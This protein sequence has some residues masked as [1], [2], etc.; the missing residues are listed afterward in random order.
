MALIVVGSANVDLVVRA[1]RLPKTGETLLG[2]SFATFPGGKGAN[3]AVAAARLGGDVRFFGCV[4]D[5]P[6]AGQLRASLL[7]AG[8][9]IDGLATDPAVPTGIA[10]ITVD[11]AGQNTIVVAPGANSRVDPQPA[12]DASQP[13]DVLLAQ[14]EI[15]VDAVERLFAETSAAVK[16]LNP[17]PACDLPP[18]LYPLI[19][20]ITPNEAEAEVLTGIRPT[21]EA[22]CEAAASELLRR[23]V[24]QVLITLGAQGC[25]YAAGSIRK[26]YPAWPV[27][28]IDTVAAGDAFSGALGHFLAIGKS[29]DT[30]IRLATVAAA[31]STTKAGAQPSLPTLADL[32]SA[33]PKSAEIEI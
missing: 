10:V 20:L 22:S 33:L 12:I 15:P 16:I 5:D 17:A 27:T 8:A 4:G 9:Q 29:V 18:A 28:A 2:E 13:G 25:F 6:F 3:Q 21:D 11:A 7:S 30:A 32:R 26:A 24:G 1:I 23:G 14:L 19:S 31:L